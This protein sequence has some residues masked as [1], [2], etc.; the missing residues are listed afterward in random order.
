MAMPEMVRFLVKHALIGMGLGAAF[1][2]ALLY[3]D[4][5][6]LQSLMMKSPSGWIAAALLAFFVGSTFAAAQMGMAVM[7]QPKDEDE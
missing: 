7:T 3:F 4:V 5:G 2:I 1:V 6:K